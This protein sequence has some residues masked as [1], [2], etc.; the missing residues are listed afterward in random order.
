[1]ASR[2]VVASFMMKDVR[3]FV[4]FAVGNYALFAPSHLAGMKQSLEAAWKETEGLFG[5]AERQILKLSEKQLAAHGLTG[6]SLALKIQAVQ[7]S[8]RWAS[9]ILRGLHPP[10]M[11]P[12]KKKVLS[13]TLD[14]IDNILDS[15][16]PIVPV[17]GPIREIKH[18]VGWAA[19]APE[20]VHSPPHVSEGVTLGGVHPE[21][22]ME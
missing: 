5:E 3:E 9:E 21:T 13:W 8:I 4:A 6:A 22:V 16:E 1:M 15:L 20:E 7:G 10:H 19:D 14:G 17:A 11:E 18:H 12:F 2:D